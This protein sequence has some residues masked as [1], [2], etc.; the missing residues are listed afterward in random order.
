MSEEE[1]EVK[2]LSGN[3]GRPKGVRIISSRPQA[4]ES[5]K[6]IRSGVQIKDEPKSEPQH[7]ITLGGDETDIG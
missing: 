6:V 7:E 1:R 3:P 4:I 2:I 5:V